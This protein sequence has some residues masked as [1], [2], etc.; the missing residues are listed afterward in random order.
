VSRISGHSTRLILK[1]ALSLTALTLVVRAMGAVKEIVFARA[2]GVSADTDAF[3][4]AVTYAM[5]LPMIIG[6][7]ISTVLI[8]SLSHRH[9][10]IRAGGL[11]TVALWVALAA[12]A[13]SVTIFVSAPV[14]MPLLFKLTEDRLASV[15]HYARVLAP[16]GAIVLLV[17]ALTA[18]LNSAKQ[19]YV[20]GI[21]AIAGPIAILLAIVVFA[22]Q[23]GVEAA[24][25]GTVV[26]GAIEVCILASRVFWQRNLLFQRSEDALSDGGV[27]MWRA[28]LLLSFASTIAALTPMVDQFFL[29]KLGTGAITHFNYASKVNSLLIGV[30]GTAFGAAIYPYLSDLAARRDVKGLTRLSWRLSAI[31][32]PITLV[33]AATVFVFS[34]EVV[35]LLFAR[36]KF[37]NDAVVEVAAIQRIFT[38]QL[39]FY[40]AMLIA[41]RILNAAGAARIILALACTSMVCNALFSW[42]LYERFGAGGVAL[43]AV[44]TSV[45]GVVCSVLLIKPALAGHHPEASPDH[46]GVAR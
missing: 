18:L 15:V 23:W 31:T 16:L 43:S 37:D 32:V 9:S 3:V 13:C 14:M 42:M 25:W 24:A 2:F 35:E 17:W 19:F 34:H 44:L 12:V 45:V 7:A 36:G 10:S 5:F 21:A 39:P 29:S 26:G 6:D 41:M 46:V 27:R 8:L 11:R 33:A 28:V 38:L 20:A 1:T 40:V 22:G 4:L 30:F